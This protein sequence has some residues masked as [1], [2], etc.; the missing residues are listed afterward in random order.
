MTTETS[1]IALRYIQRR[2]L[3]LSL[4][5]LGLL[6]AVTVTLARTYHA[7]EEALVRQWLAK[8]NADLSAGQPSKALE[9]FRNA[10]SYGPENNLV[11]FRLAEAL[12][13]ADRL[14]EAH[15]YFLNLWDQ[16][17]GSG[18]V[19]LELAHTS[20]R[21]GETEAAIRYYRGA[22]YGG[23]NKDPAQQRR[24]TRLELCEFLFAQGRIGDAQAELAGLAADIPREDAILHEKT[25]QLFLRADE[26][27]RALAE[28]ETALRSNPR[29]NQWLEDAGKA[30][31]A[32]GDYTKAATYLAR[33]IRENPS[34]EIHGLLETAREVLDGD[35]FLPGLSDKV[36]AQRSWR[37]FQQALERLQKCTGTNAAE[38]FA[39]Q[40]SSD[41]Q[42]LIKDS[43][44]LQGRLNL[45]SLSEHPELRNAAMQLVF[46]I[47]ETTSHTCGAPQGEDLA[48]VLIGKKHSG[49]NP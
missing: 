14:P 46:R 43:H 15:A 21:M 25:G 6:F 37:A 20:M 38:Q 35:P 1:N 42:V 33:A 32:D 19:N 9:D 3:L 4:I 28:F 48:L 8:G 34:D 27:D 13:A 44:D 16:T 29:Q 36:Q 24:N 7:R 5:P 39:A 10:L 18:E 45:R 47:E 31:Y 49:R 41:L 12:L 30:A 40:P 23:W 2:V 26:P 11:Q 17:P 22:I